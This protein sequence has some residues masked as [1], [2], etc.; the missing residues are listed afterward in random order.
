MIWASGKTV[1]DAAASYILC[2]WGAS[3]V[4]GLRGCVPCSVATCRT[5][6]DINSSCGP[7]L[8]DRDLSL[9]GPALGMFSGLSGLFGCSLSST[10]HQPSP[11]LFE[12]SIL[13]LRVV[14]QALGFCASGYCCTRNQLYSPLNWSR[15]N[16]MGFS[17]SCPS[18]PTV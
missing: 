12:K 11:C 7:R 14:Y 1:P 16:S 18:G 17:T 3:W 6:S 8:G 10:F 9:L 15:Q 4:S 13:C 2:V 5:A